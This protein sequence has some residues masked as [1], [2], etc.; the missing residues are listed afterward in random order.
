M[1]LTFWSYSYL[2]VI[3]INANS[4][5]DIHTHLII[6]EHFKSMRK[7]AIPV[8]HTG[9]GTLQARLPGLAPLFL[10]CGWGHLRFPYVKQ[11]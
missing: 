8:M 10:V 1:L 6:Q 9:A 11:G 3:R 2:E 5:W 4:L 7:R